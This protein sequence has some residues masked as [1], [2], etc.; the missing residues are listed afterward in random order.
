LAA[1][2]WLKN[3]SSRYP[4]PSVTRTVT[5]DRRWRVWRFFTSWT[6]AITV[7]SAPILT[8]RIVSTR[9]RSMYRRG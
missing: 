7:T 4:V 8:A 6:V 9:E 5:I 2:G 3:V 1:H